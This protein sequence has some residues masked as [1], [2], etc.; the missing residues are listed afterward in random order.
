ME[1]ALIRIKDGSR[2]LA[3][4]ED[5]VRKTYK[6]YFENLFNVDTE[7]KDTVNICGILKVQE[8]DVIWWKSQ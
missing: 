7:E 8:G 2:W 3:M 4:G 5:N 1:I 6:E